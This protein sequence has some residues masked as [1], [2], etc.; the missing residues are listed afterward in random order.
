MALC[1][2]WFKVR[3]CGE[4]KQKDFRQNSQFPLLIHQE[5]VY[6]K[7]L[8]VPHVLERVVSIASFVRH[9]ELNDKQISSFLCGAKAVSKDVPIRQRGRIV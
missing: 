7:I 4:A 5:V 8:K 2:D 1:N 9:R 3:C 6:G